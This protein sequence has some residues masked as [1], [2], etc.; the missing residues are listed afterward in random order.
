M[1]ET[2]TSI[3]KYQPNKR[4]LLVFEMTNIQQR[5]AEVLFFFENPLTRKPEKERSHK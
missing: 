5:N 1:A 2:D 3:S 4:W